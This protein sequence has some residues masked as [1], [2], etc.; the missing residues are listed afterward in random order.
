MGNMDYMEEF[1][2]SYSYPEEAAKAILSTYINVITNDLQYN[3]WKQAQEILFGDEAVRPQF[4]LDI[5][6]HLAGQAGISEY[7]MYLAFHIEATRELQLRYKKHG[8]PD[9]IQRETMGDL[10]TKAKECKRMTGGYGLYTP[11]WLYKYYRLERFAFGRMQ[12]ELGQFMMDSCEIGGVTIKKGDPVLR[13]HVPSNG[14]PFDD[15]ARL[16]SYK[17]VYKFCH[18]FLNYRYLEKSYGEISKAMIPI[19]CYGWLLFPLN[20]NILPADSN[21]VK[22]MHEFKVLRTDYDTCGSELRRIFG[23]KY[24]GNPDELPVTSTLQVGYKKWLQDGNDTGS[25]Y[26]ILLFDGQNIITE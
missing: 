1:L 9:Q 19:T 12:Y 5:L 23:V 25:S 15:E 21:I 4:Y 11:A 8:I 10:L 14:K 20:E 2:E 24:N 18:I 22:F 26:G 17:Q 16:D 6:K 3:K 7:L 13:C